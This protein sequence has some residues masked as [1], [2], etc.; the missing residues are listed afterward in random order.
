MNKKGF[1]AVELLILI[2]VLGILATFI[3]IPAISNGMELQKLM[4]VDSETLALVSK[5]MKQDFSVTVT[6][7][8]YQAV[9]THEN[10]SNA[11]DDG[12]ATVGLLKKRG[13]STS[14]IRL[15]FA[16]KEGLIE[17]TVPAPKEDGVYLYL[18]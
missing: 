14:R 8:V 13:I 2:V 7:V 16:N 11:V 5:A 3:I 10:T 18:E 15:L 6:V 17:D 4:P 9:W 12:K 1:T